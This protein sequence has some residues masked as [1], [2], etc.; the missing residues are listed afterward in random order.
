[1]HPE[2][3]D[4][5]AA[6]WEIARRAQHSY[7]KQLCMYPPLVANNIQILN[8]WK[9]QGLDLF[10]RAATWVDLHNQIKNAKL[11]YRN[12]LGLFT[13]AVTDFSSSNSGILI[14]TDFAI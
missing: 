8:Q 14:Y 5:A 13:S 3:P 9:K 7:Q 6:A 10:T 1:L 12:Q 11:K 2:L 4:A